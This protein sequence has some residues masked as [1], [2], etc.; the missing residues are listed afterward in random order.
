MLDSSAYNCC[1][2]RLSNSCNSFSLLVRPEE[3]GR[4]EDFFKTEAGI[5]CR[6]ETVLGSVCE[7]CKLV[8]GVKLR[9][10][11]FDGAGGA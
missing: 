3:A 5:V 6:S 8:G 2:R 11:R 7:F 9:A 1:C 4:V 10:G